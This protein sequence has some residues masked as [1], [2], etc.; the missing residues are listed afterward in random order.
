MTI[1]RRLR[2]LAA[3]ASLLQLT[4]PATVALADARLDVRPAAPIHVESGPSSTC[5]PI[6]P[7]QCALCQFLSTF[8][9]V[10][11]SHAVPLP[12]PPVHVIAVRDVASSIGIARRIGRLAR[13]PPLLA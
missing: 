9:P 11:G 6:H 7:D 12:D 4:L 5:A 2:V 3:F 1:T 13:A 8:Q 10:G